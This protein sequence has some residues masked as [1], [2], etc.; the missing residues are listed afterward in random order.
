VT[1]RHELAAGESLAEVVGDGPALVEFHAEWCA[2]C[3]VLATFVDEVREALT[4]PVVRV[5]VERR[6][7]VADAHDVTTNPTL[8]VLADGT[9]RE[10]V[11]GL[12]D[13]TEFRAAVDPWLAE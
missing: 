5:D 3:A 10:R 8:L 2:P 13:R 4:V 11:A 12:P 9:V 7:D 1:D 6:P